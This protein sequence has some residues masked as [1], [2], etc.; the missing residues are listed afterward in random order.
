MSSSTWETWVHRRRRGKRRSKRI[1]LFGGRLHI[2]VQFKRDVCT[3][4]RQRLL[5]FQDRERSKQ[6]PSCSRCFRGTNLNEA[7]AESTTDLVFLSR[8]NRLGGCEI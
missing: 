7:P 5:L 8:K 3:A 4:S 6:Q 1:R 2:C